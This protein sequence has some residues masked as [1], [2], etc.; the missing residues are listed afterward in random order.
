MFRI[1]ILGRGVQAMLLGQAARSRQL[2]VR[3]LDPSPVHPASV[4]SESFTAEFD[5]LAALDAFTYEMDAVTV[6]G[7]AVPA[8]ALLNC[9]KTCIIAPGI[10][11]LECG[12]DRLKTKELC[13]KL[14]IPCT[15]GM[16]ARSLEEVDQAL[17]AI[18]F[19]VVLVPRM[20]GN[21]ERFP[22][23]LTRR[24]HA[25]LAWEE[26]GSKEY[27]FEQFTNPERE[28]ACMAARSKNGQ[29]SSYPLTELIRAKGL[30]Q[31]MIAPA[32]GLSPEAEGAAVAATG[33]LLDELEHVGM[34]CVTFFVRGKEAILDT[35][36]PTVHPAGLWTFE[37]S[38]TNQ[39]ENQ[40][41]ALTE[42]ELGPGTGMLPCR[43]IRLFGSVPHNIKDLDM[44]N[45][46][47]H[48]YGMG[49]EADD[50]SVAHLTVMGTDRPDFPDRWKK[51]SKALGI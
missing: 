42:E 28:I 31:Q 45:I 3:T 43:T 29:I 24:E 35:I 30:L 18:G 37:G 21:D 38:Q 44:D 51:L 40:I 14:R 7:P 49:Q 46:M 22:P 17:A 47:V 8:S 26:C 50:V 6:E 4:L 2:S 39:Y 15:R 23:I 32:A 10:R 19:P 41:R 9:S 11:A 27:I 36:T 1:G 12:Q 48:M 34:L 13:Q 16:P 25:I 5:D 20:R 33:A